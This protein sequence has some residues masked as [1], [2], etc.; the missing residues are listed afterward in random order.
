[1]RGI[2]AA[3]LLAQHKAD[4]LVAKEV[5]EGPYHVLR[6]S[7]IQIFDLNEESD[8]ERVLDAFSKK[9]LKSLAHPRESG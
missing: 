3:H 6:D 1:L 9:E 7:S 5:G 8:I 4:V 2:E